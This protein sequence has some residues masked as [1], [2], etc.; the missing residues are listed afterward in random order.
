MLFRSWAQHTG[1]ELDMTVT[2][3]TTVFGC[4]LEIYHISPRHTEDS[5]NFRTEITILTRSGSEAGLAE[6]QSQPGEDSAPSFSHL[7]IGN[8]RNE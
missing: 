1:V 5:S 4:R 2:G 6:R 7:P 8:W 3:D